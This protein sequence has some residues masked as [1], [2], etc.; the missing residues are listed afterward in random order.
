LQGEETIET[1]ERSITL[2]RQPTLTV[3]KF[4]AGDG[5]VKERE[6][7]V[8][9][10]WTKRGRHRIQATVAAKPGKGFR[11]LPEGG[12]YA[13]F[14][15]DAWMLCDST[16]ARRATLHLELSDVPGTGW[17]AVGPGDRGGM[18]G[19]YAL[20]DQKEPVQTYLFSFA[21]AKMRWLGDGRFSYVAP[22]QDR[23]KLMEVTYDAFAYFKSRAGSEPL[24]RNYAQAFLPAPGMAQEAAGMALM[25]VPYLGELEGKDNLYLLAHEMA[26]QW[27]GVSTG[28]KSWSDFWLNEGFA[29][30]MADSY[31]ERKQGR[32]VYD[33]RIERLKERMA[34][35]RSEGK[36][37]PLHWDKWKD[38]QDALG[39][40]PYVK[41]ALLLDSL[42]TELGD[43]VF[44]R[45]IAAYTTA[46]KG[47][48]VDT[49]DFVRAME[50]SSKR[51][52]SAWFEERAYR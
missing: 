19:G 5:F 43:E 17:T 44:W 37:R 39:D 42:R 22:E 8:E 46:T 45:G 23:R 3:S 34:K 47:K 29:E 2:T 40:L 35:L 18:V 49:A 48:L 52:L 13:V 38:A 31:L 28:I 51:E 21:M 15:C 50:K 12:F 25:S 36:D 27:W 32:A 33:Q 4:Y 11:F 41:G 16:P 7:G 1:S 24:N 6:D 26:H 14:Y 9:I 10:S 30:F 20:F